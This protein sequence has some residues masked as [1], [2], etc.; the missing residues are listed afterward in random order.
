M[1]EESEDSVNLTQSPVEHDRTDEIYLDLKVNSPQLVHD[2]NIASHES[3]DQTFGAG[4][5]VAHDFA[6][7][8]DVI[9]QEPEKVLSPKTLQKIAEGINNVLTTM[10]DSGED[11]F[12]KLTQM[13]SPEDGK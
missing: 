5:G 13:Q 1:A 4:L 10:G 2:L 3:R 12:S 8:A 7:V 9:I 6:E 11:V